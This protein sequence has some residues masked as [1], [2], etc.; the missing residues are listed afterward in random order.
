VTLTG[1]TVVDPLTGQNISGVTLAPGA[2]Q[3][4]NTSYTLTQADLNGAGN[5]G[6]DHDID[7]TATAD[8]NETGPVSDSE[9]VPLVYNP[10]LTIDKA[11]SS[12]TDA[13]NGMVDNAGDVIN[14]TITV[15]N[16]GNVDLTGVTVTD[17]IE[18]Y[19]ATN[20]AFVSGD[21]GDNVLE[22]GETWIYSAS[23]TVTQ[24]DLTNH[25]GG[26]NDID[27]TATADSNETAPA[28]DSAVALLYY[29]P[30][31]GDSITLEVNEAALSTA[32]AT[33]SNPALTT[34]VDNTPTLS[35][36]AGTNALTSFKFS[37]D[38]TGLVTDLNGDTVTDIYWDRV[39]DTQIKGYLDP[40]H[41][42][43]AVTLDL[44]APASIAAF[45]TGSVTVTMTLSDNLQ[46]PNDLGAQISPVGSIDIDAATAGGD[47]ATGT[48]NLTVQDD[49]PTKAIPE[50]AVL[51]N[52]AGLPFVF[53]LDNDATMS[54]NFGADGGTIR[55]P[56]SLDGAT[57][58]LTSHGVPIIYDVSPDG[59][60]LLGIA[61]STTVFEITLNPGTTT[62]SVD[63]ND[64]VDSRT[65][66]DF[67][68]GGYN[69]EG[70]NTE[71]NRF[72]PVGET[73]AS[74]IDNNSSDLL[75]TPEIGGVPDGT[76]NTSAI[77]GGVGTGASVG[78]TADGPETFRVDFVTDVSG[79]PHSVGGGDYD[80]ATKRD[81]VFDG[82]YLVNGSTAVFTATSGST[83]NIAAST[84]LDGNNV[85]GDAPVLDAITAVSI[86]FNGDA[87]LID[88][89]DPLAPSYSVGG[90]T[91]TVTLVGDGSINV[92]G[93]FGDS[94]NSTQIGIFVAD[95]GYN[96]V[97]Y[98]WAGGDT[99]KIGD[100]GAS[101]PSTDPVSFDV[102]IQVV[103]GDGDTA[104]SS[105]GITLAS[106]AIHDYS[107][108][109]VP[110]TATAGS[111][112]TPEL[113]I[114][115]SNF[116]D[117]LTGN[118]AANVLSGGNGDDTLNGLGANDTL[119]GGSDNDKF[120][121]Q[122][123]GG[124]VDVLPD[125][126]S[127]TDQIVVDVAS[128]SLTIGT[129]TVVAAGNFHT[130]TDENLAGAWTGGSGGN[131]FFFNTSNSNLYY[132]AA[133][134]GSDVIQLAHMTTGVPV[135]SDIHTY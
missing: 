48:V 41:T 68:S 6:G 7:N 114:I 127:G 29:H 99:F 104:D 38:L 98:T 108:S 91:F 131:E 57:S 88:L 70:G 122:G 71:W 83:V 133:G 101:V 94:N 14:Y 82:H 119:I 95:G 106:S 40:G 61:G 35:F 130:G 27:N 111:V 4:F 77:A 34:E 76:I 65:Q 60:H 53:D 36:T 33:G 44:S 10:A 69:F 37:T 56:A 121:L 128:Q 105:I 87:L 51:P 19:G 46:H 3:T 26:D 67:S 49:L 97:A 42:L 78:N 86:S 55:F 22:V 1:V 32:G 74:P 84:D 117:V 63:M 85:V 115:G 125:F 75:L 18:S 54:N 126:V 123:S 109:G 11:V 13:F 5:A 73:V 17:Q 20:A 59:L 39:S 52:G 50:Y 45:T 23:Y 2:S 113:N 79:N 12:I 8:S 66:V 135:A 118:S 62:Y 72:V 134:D 81:H 47:T 9:Q 58:G 132:S 124:G 24:T 103:D 129:S 92:G 16:T 28:S 93:V 25:G 112:A 96:S 31:A 64:V 21:D 15:D 120:V 110:V 100:F 30:E 80:T 89:T 116:D 90:H 43:L 102:P 107:A